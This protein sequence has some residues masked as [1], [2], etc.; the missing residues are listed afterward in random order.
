M[1][2]AQKIIKYLALAFAFFII[3]NIISVIL[4]GLN[5]L[6][7]ILGLKKSNNNLENEQIGDLEVITG[8]LQETEITNLKIDIKYSN[9]KIEQG[10]YLK[11]E[12]NYKDISCKQNN[13]QITI[14]ENGNKWYSKKDTSDIIIYIPEEMEFEE[15][16]IEAGAGKI[17]IANLTT[18]ELDF[19]IGAGKVKIDRL[20]V[21]NQAKID[22]GAGKVDILSGEIHNLDLNMGVGE[23]VLNSKLIGN[24]K[25]EQGVGK[26]IVNLTDDLENYRIKTSKGIGSITIDGNKVEDEGTYGNGENYIKIEGGIGTVEIK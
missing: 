8:N 22:G 21:L 16:K 7:N 4:F 6:S 1:S 17:E 20:T 19:D 14:K 24:N 2:T 13:N 12:S 11:V 3:V 18:K 10:E 23:F 5:N 9:L 26:L 25:I 15:V